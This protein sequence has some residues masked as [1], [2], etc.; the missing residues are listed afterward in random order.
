MESLWPDNLSG[1]VERA[2]VHLL[3][4]QATL[5]GQQTGNLV[6]GIVKRR[7]RGSDEFGFAFR[8]RSNILEYEYELFIVW[9]N[10]SLYPLKIFPNSEIGTDQDLV[11]H[12]PEE[13]L[14]SGTLMIMRPGWPRRMVPHQAPHRVVK[15]RIAVQLW[16]ITQ[17]Q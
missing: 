9:H 3:K 13:F 12:V 15:K 14:L 6:T 7:S 17:I 11:I 5:L 1:K 4:E 2:P 10:V 8:V 16:L